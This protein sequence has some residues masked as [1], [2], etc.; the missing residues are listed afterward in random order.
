MELKTVYVLGLFILL[1]SC[2]SQLPDPSPTSSEQCTAGYF[3]QGSLAGPPG[4]PGRDGQSGLPGPAGPPG[5]PGAPGASGVD[6]DELRQI[7]RLMAKE[8]LKNMTSETAQPVKVVVEHNNVCPTTVQATPTNRP[9]TNPSR[10][11]YQPRLPPPTARP[12][13]R[14]RA[15]QSCSLGLS[16]HDPGDSC[17][18]ILRCNRYLASG[19]YW[20][21]LRNRPNWNHVLVRVYCHME[22]DICGVGGLT[23][24][25]YI[26]MTEPNAQC[27]YPL[28]ETT[29]SGKRICYSPTNGATFSSVEYDT[30]SVKYNFVCGRAV[31]ITYNAPWGFYY[32]STYSTLDMSYAAG[33]SITYKIDGA[34]THIWTYAAGYRESGGDGANCPCA[35]N[36]GYTPQSFLGSNFYCDTAAHTSGSSNWFVN[37]SLWDGKDCYSSSNCC[38]NKRLPWFWTTLADETDSDIEVRWMDPQARSA[39]ITGITLLELYVY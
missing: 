27:P 9:L 19:W 31:G 32:K 34:R 20:I 8:E 15:N 17:R 7:V 26:N 25:A 18:D 35:S 30:H 22:D 29:E 2:F 21:K 37:N 13:V 5:A 12:N 3:V 28:S 23:R 1:D 10:P 33:L 39:G 38:T 6:L 11:T 4:S 16:Y 14:P 36:P 24:V